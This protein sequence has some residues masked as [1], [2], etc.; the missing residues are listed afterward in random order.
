M[1][2]TISFSSNQIREDAILVDYHYDC[3]AGD[4][5]FVLESDGV[6]PFGLVVGMGYYVIPRPHLG[7]IELATTR[8]GALAGSPVTITAPGSGSHRLRLAP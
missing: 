8:D 7:G 3:A 1:V 4:G 2:Q 6:A 5:P